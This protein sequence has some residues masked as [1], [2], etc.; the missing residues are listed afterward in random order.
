MIDESDSIDVVL[1]HPSLTDSPYPMWKKE[2][3]LIT[4]GPRAELQELSELL[5]DRGLI[6]GC[7]GMGTCARGPWH[8]EGWIR[9][10][11]VREGGGFESVISRREGCDSKTGEF[12]LMRFA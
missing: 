9:L 3:A 8:W 10:P 5:E 4:G 6:A 1:V 12:R 11:E 7:I 2:S